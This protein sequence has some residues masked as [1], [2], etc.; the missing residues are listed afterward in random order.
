MSAIKGIIEKGLPT[1]LESGS[2]AERQWFGEMTEIS[3]CF[4]AND[5]RLKTLIGHREP[6]LIRIAT[7]NGGCALYG[8]YIGLP[9]GTYEAAIRFDPEVPCYG[10]AVV[11]VCAAIGRDVVVRR[12]VTADQIVGEDMGA[13]IRFSSDGPLSQVEVRLYPEGEFSAGIVAVEIKG[14]AKQLAQ[15]VS[16]S[17]LP[18]VNVE[19]AIRK[20]RNLYDGYQRAIGLGNTNLSGRIAGDPDFLRARKLAAARTIVGEP[21]LENI[22]LLIKFYLPRLPFGH[23]VE[24]GSY[25]GGSAIFMAALAEIF[26]PGAEVFAFDTFTGMQVT[27][28]AVDAHG[29][30]DF[31]DVDLV[32]LRQY[33]EQIGLTNLTFVQGRFEETSP[34]V[35]QK[36]PLAL[37]HMDCDLRSAVE[38]AY[39]TAR[40]YMVPGGYWVFD[41]AFIPDCVGEAE[42]IE[43]LLI[44]RDGLNSEQLYPHYVF[45]EPFEKVLPR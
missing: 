34:A 24:F 28:R 4:L 40:P 27:D 17:D 25:K 18:E 22:F 14:V 8:P 13:R 43:D 3:H 35:L 37:V 10:T 44:R 23:I 30:G 12:T 15:H 38:Y 16:I 32:E 29:D 6:N 7:P 21:N 2:S 39:D 31:S 20:G 26:L 41:D 36:K 19:N 45:R 42:A 1:G 33:I 5:P 9:A 11:D